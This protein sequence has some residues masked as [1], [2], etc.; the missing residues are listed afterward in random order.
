[1][2]GTILQVSQKIQRRQWTVFNALR[3]SERD[4][5]NIHTLDF[6][7]QAGFLPIAE[8]LWRGGDYLRQV[9]AVRGESFSM[10]QQGYFVISQQ[11]PIAYSI[12]ASANHSK[13]PE[14]WM[15]RFTA[16]FKE[17]ILAFLL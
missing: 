12:H 3:K 8:G 17:A 9:P 13:R 2:G 6:E 10:R 16:A 14:P 5:V 7:K 15:R 11:D 4:L 1:M